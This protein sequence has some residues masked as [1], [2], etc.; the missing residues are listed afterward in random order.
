ME[1]VTAQNQTTHLNSVGS[2]VESTWI[3]FVDQG[4]VDT[5]WPAAAGANVAEKEI[6]TRDLDI[7]V[8]AKGR[9]SVQFLPPM[10]KYRME[11]NGNYYNGCTWGDRA[12]D[13]VV[14][15]WQDFKYRVGRQYKYN[16]D[17]WMLRRYF[18]I[19][20]YRGA[21]GLFDKPL[22]ARSL[23][24]EDV[25]NTIVRLE[26]CFKYGISANNNLVIYAFHHVPA[27]LVHGRDRQM[28]KVVH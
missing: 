19:F 18:Q 2:K 15:L 21:S 17:N 6:N 4:T 5:T 3:T 7:S 26:T 12:D 24:G 23:Q 14:G 11:I 8:K 20:D 1:N 13:H 16:M 10:T 22:G 25:N 28:V 27:I 9:D